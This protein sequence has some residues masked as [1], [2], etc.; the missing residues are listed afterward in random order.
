MG[1]RSEILVCK[2]VAI[3]SVFDKDSND[4]NKME[5]NQGVKGTFEDISSS[6]KEDLQNILS[7]QALNLGIKAMLTLGLDFDTVKGGR[8][9]AVELN[10]SQL[11]YFRRYTQG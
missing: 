10:T 3:D 8:E 2:A 4:V 7:R 1:K 6:C 5:A 9:V 11:R